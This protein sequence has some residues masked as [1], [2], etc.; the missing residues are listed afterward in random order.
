MYKRLLPTALAGMTACALALGVSAC[1][2]GGDDDDVASPTPTPVN[3][4]ICFT[5]F[6]DQSASMAGRFNVYI[7]QTAASLMNQGAGAYQVN[8]DAFDSSVGFFYYQDDGTLGSVNNGI[9]I[10]TNGAWTIN[11]LTGVEPGNTLDW[12][13]NDSQQYFDTDTG[14]LV[15]SNGTGNWSGTL[16]DPEDDPIAGTGTITIAHMGSSLEM[17]SINYSMCVNSNAFAPTTSKELAPAVRAYF[18]DKV[19]Q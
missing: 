13:D 12:E 18:A 10:T 16:S 7:W 4:D 17:S 1:S 6:A 11:S 5:I 2:G 14:A 19:A 8:T 3:P 9:S 15:G